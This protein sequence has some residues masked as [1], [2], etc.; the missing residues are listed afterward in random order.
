MTEQQRATSLGETGGLPGRNAVPEAAEVTADELKD[1]VATGD[2][3]VV[4]DD[5]GGQESP[6]DDS[7]GTEQPGSGPGGNGGT[8]PVGQPSP[9]QVRRLQERDG[10]VAT[11]NF[12]S[13]LT[14]DLGNAEV[15]DDAADA[16]ETQ[17]PDA[18]LGHEGGPRYE[19]SS[20]GS[21][22]RA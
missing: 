18:S 1:T 14:G 8:E 22:G 19:E 20:G 9:E 6:D 3:A 21:G 12:G 11:A 5:A 2:V 13:A 17:T 10:P 15:A 4:P 16:P 7:I